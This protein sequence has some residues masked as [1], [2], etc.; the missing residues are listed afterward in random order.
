MSKQRKAQ[1]QR[2]IHIR[3]CNNVE[4]CGMDLWRGDITIRFTQ[5]EG[6]GPCVVIHANPG[7]FL[8]IARALRGGIRQMRQRLQK[9]EDALTATPQED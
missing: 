8:W 7:V 5:A 2:T 3:H 1:R 6:K 9:V 4:L